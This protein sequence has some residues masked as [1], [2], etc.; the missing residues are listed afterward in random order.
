MNAKLNRKLSSPRPINPQNSLRRRIIARPF[1]TIGQQAHQAER[2]APVHSR[3]PADSNAM[4]LQS[5]SFDQPMIKSFEVF[6][7]RSDFTQ[8]HVV[9]HRQLEEGAGI[10]RS[11]RFD[12]RFFR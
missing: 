1:R 7:L 5:L 9:A 2:L 6:P 8:R 11:G 4:S 3:Y 12:E 10:P